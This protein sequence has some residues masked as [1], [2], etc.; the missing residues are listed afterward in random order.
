M[1][2]FNKKQ[3]KLISVSVALV[4]VLGVVGIALSQSAVGVASAAAAPSNVG[5]VDHQS[6]I[7]QHPDM[8]DA[9]TAMQKEI[10]SAKADFDAK[11]AD[12]N[13]Q[14]KQAYYQQIQQR[15]AN[16]E[17]ELIQPIFDK[18]DAAIKSVAEKRGLTV[19]LD[20]NNVIYGGQ[21]I[22]VE[23]GQKMAK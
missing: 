20:K 6:L 18:V 13:P 12:M 21:D 8:A 19:V 14:E 3:I 22:T 7:A 23:V 1:M 4:F 15:L 16:K 5:I 9:K 11:S 2:K 17:K 10:E